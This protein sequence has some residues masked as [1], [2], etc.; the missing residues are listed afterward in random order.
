MN[1]VVKNSHEEKI[2]Q[3]TLNCLLHKVRATKMVINKYSA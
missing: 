3:E 1:N 2:A